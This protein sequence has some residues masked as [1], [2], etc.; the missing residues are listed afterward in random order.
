MATP[1]LLIKKSLTNF[2]NVWSKGNMFSV[3][4]C[5]QNDIY[6]QCSAVR[7]FLLQW[8]AGTCHSV[9]GTHVHYSHTLG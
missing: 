4:E 6:L 8:C 7:A 1:G 3:H 5:L 2:F 9:E